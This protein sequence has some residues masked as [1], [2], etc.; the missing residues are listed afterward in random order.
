[1]ERPKAPLRFPS[2]SAI[3][4]PRDLFSRNGPTRFAQSAFAV[5]TTLAV[6]FPREP[7]DHFSDRVA[8]RVPTPISQGPAKN[9]APLSKCQPFACPGVPLQGCS[10]PPRSVGL[11]RPSPHEL[12]RVTQQAELRTGALQGIPRSGPDGQPRLP[13]NPRGVLGSAL[14]FYCSPVRELFDRLSVSRGAPVGISASA[15]SSHPL[16]RLGIPAGAW[17]PAALP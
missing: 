12:P 5:S 7:C 15:T 10:R 2:L 6:L 11:T 17:R 14:F 1:M 3:I 13:S 8:L 4:N 16:R 9:L